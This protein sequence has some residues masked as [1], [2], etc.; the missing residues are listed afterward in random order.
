MCNKIPYNT[1]Q[2]AV[3]H[4]EFL[5][6]NPRTTIDKKMRAYPCKDCGNWHLTS[7]SSN[8]TRIYRR[9]YRNNKK[10]LKLIAEFKALTNNVDRFK[11]ITKHQGKWMELGI[12]DERTYVVFNG[13]VRVLFD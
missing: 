6:K 10:Q 12:Y 11:W 7:V 2:E 5:R 9:S 1:K 4:Y 3:N 13:K 8:K